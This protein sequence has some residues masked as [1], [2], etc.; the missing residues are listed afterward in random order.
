MKGTVDRSGRGRVAV[1]EAMEVWMEGR[2]YRMD[3]IWEAEGV[4]REMQRK[5]KHEGK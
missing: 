1:V 2:K 4:H 3:G 5:R